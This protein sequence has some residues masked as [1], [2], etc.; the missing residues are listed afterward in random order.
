MTVASSHQP[1]PLNDK[2]ASYDLK[3]AVDDNRLAGL[4]R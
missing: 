2:L 1:P 4:W 3:Q